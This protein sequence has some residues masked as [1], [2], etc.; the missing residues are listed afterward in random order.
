MELAVDKCAM[1]NK[2]G[3]EKDFELLNQNLN[4]LK[5]VKG[6]G[7]NVSKI[8]TWSVHINPRLNKANRVL[9]L[10]RRN[11]AYAV[12]PFIKLGL[13]KLLVLPVL[14]YGVNCTTPSKS[15]SGKH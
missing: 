12:K 13:Y 7:I 15:D 14:L 5:A 8:L 9:Y 1:L 3:P 11:V 4:S 2:R 6:I 10:I